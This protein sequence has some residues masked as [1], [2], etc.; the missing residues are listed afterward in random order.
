[1]AAVLSRTHDNCQ[2][3]WSRMQEKCD[4]LPLVRVIRVL[5]NRHVFPVKEVAGTIYPFYERKGEGL[6]AQ[7][8]SKQGDCDGD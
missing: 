3:N 7:V 2:I 6:D 8:E 1:M 5:G 4:I